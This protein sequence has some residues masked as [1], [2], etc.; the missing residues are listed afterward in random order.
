M[1]YVILSANLLY[2]LSDRPRGLTFAS[3]FVIA[4]TDGKL[5][6]FLR[7][8]MHVALRLYYNLEYYSFG[9][10]SF[11]FIMLRSC[12]GV[13]SCVVVDTE[14]VKLAFL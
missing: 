8:C 2:L 7:S 14:G 4:F 1:S 5:C 13:I 3:R 6:C 10:Y 9:N 11:A 12:K